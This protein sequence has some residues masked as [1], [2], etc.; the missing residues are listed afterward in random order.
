M[1]VFSLYTCAL[2]SQEAHGRDRQNELSQ[3]GFS[4]LYHAD[5]R[6]LE[7]TL[8]VA[9]CKVCWCQMMISLFQDSVIVGSV[10][11]HDWRGVLYEVR[12]SAFSEIKDP[13]VNKDSYM[14]ACLSIISVCVC[15]EEFE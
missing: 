14:G 6:H 1:N 13:A 12:G 11:S 8:Q 9:S 3:S 2:G 5:V 4:V 15:C 7:Y 10:G